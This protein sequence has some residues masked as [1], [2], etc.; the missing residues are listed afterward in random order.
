MKLGLTTVS[1]SK[2]QIKS[3]KSNLPKRR[4]ERTSTL[5]CL[6]LKSK[7]WVFEKT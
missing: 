6:H 3:W 7:K 2:S 5:N 1:R 4:S